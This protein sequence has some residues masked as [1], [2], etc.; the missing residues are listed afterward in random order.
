MKTQKCPYTKISEVE[1]NDI[2]IYSNNNSTSSKMNVNFQNFSLV[3]KAEAQGLQNI[4]ATT[5][6]LSDQLTLPFLF[7]V[8]SFFLFIFLM[9]FVY[10]YH[11][12]KFT[13]NDKLIRSF[14]PI[15]FFGL[16][17]LSVPLIYN[18]FF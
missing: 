14:V 17:I 16:T 5:K 7:L 1:A 11:W 18:L 12:K 10:F 6:T 2:Q 15:Y 13:T 3:S 4:S 9:S 8:L